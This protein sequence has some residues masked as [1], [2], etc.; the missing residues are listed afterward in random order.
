MKSFDIHLPGL[1]RVI[2]EFR[3]GAENVVAGFIVAVVMIGVG[4]AVIG[5]CS[6]GRSGTRKSPWRS[7]V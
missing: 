7:S 5:W 2:D 6:S 3:A 4:L 1:G